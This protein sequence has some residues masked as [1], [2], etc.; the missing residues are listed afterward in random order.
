MPLLPED[1]TYLEERGI[2]YRIVIESGVEHVLFAQG[3]SD[4]YDN[5]QVEIA[6]KIPAGY[7]MTPWDMFWVS[8]TIRLRTGTY[9][10]ASETF[11]NF[12][13]RK[14]QRFSRHLPSWRPGVD[15][16]RSFLPLVLAE[17]TR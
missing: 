6:L 11:E 15:S 2:E 5:S 10:P 1:E 17:L 8:P 13:G 7:R 12:L 14:W 4:R 16:L 9:P 3:L